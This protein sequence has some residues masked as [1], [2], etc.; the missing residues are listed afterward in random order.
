MHFSIVHREILFN[1][2]YRHSPDGLLEEPWVTNTPHA[3]CPLG[4]SISAFV[5]GQRANQVH[6]AEEPT[7][8]VPNREDNFR[9]SL[10]FFI[11]NPGRVNEK[12]I[13]A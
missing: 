6:T 9:T 4:L 11:K 13:C 1:V 3:D 7:V 12:I 2:F 10:D 8:V 5:Q